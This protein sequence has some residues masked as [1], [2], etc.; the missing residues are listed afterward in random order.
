MSNTCDHC[1]HEHCTE[2]TPIRYDIATDQKVPITQA[3][4][5]EIVGFL[6]SM[7]KRPEGLPVGE[8]V[9]I[10]SG[11]K[12]AAFPNRSRIGQCFIAEAKE[13]ESYKDSD[14]RV[15]ISWETQ[16][17][18]YPPVPDTKWLIHGDVNADFAAEIVRRWNNFTDI[19]C[20]VPLETEYTTND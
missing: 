7:L 9:T 4:W 14:G 6:K 17:P 2:G 1:G 13:I 12:L 20:D 8:S 15:L 19:S 3:D 18:Y 10:P 5:D 11:L 16:Q